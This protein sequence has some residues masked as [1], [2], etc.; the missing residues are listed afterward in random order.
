MEL[1]DNFLVALQANPFWFIGVLE[2]TACSCL[3]VSNRS[4]ECLC[5]PGLVLSACKTELARA[6]LTCTPQAIYV[7]SINCKNMRERVTMPD[8]SMHD[9]KRI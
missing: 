8:F 1:Y 2:L 9:G 6:L 3:V 5:A 4:N 7:R